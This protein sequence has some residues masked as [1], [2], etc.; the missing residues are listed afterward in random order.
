MPL[1]VCNINSFEACMKHDIELVMI[2][3]WLAF[4]VQDS[5]HAFILQWSSTRRSR[6][7]GDKW[8]IYPAHNRSTIYSRCL[9]YHKAFRFLINSAIYKESRFLRFIMFC[10]VKRHICF[11][12][13]FRCALGLQSHNNFLFLCLIWSRR[14]AKGA[15]ARHRWPQN[16]H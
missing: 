4:D 1:L 11:L 14:V 7:Y 8:P 5:R 9:S 16:F 10:I 15:R 3:F 12:I 13:Q 2:S 6:K